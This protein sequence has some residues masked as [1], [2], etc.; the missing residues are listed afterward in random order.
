MFAKTALTLLAVTAHIM[1]LLEHRAVCM[2]DQCDRVISNQV[3]Y[4]GLTLLPRLS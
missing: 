3:T 2:L 1:T 4:I